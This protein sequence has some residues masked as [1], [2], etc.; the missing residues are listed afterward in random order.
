MRSVVFE[1]FGE[2]A[3]VLRIRD[4]PDPSPASGQVRVRM[5]AS[6]VNPSDLLMVRGTYTYLPQLPATPGFE[7]VGIVEQNGGGILGKYLMGKRVAV[8]NAAN[9]GWCEQAI[10]STH[11]AIPLPADL[12]QD[13]AA[14]F[15][16]NPATA[17]I[18]TRI[19]FAIPRGEWLLQTAAGS[20]LGKMVIRLGKKYGFRTL[21]IVRRPEIAEELRKLGGDE[22]IVFDPAKDD[23]GAFQERVRKIVGGTGVRYAIDP[24]GGKTAGAVAATLGHGGR[25]YLFGSLSQQP[26]ELSSRMMVTTGARIEGFWLGRWTATHGPLTKLKLVRKI[27]RLMREGII[28]TEVAERFPLDRVADAARAADQPGRRGK[29]L[30]EMA[31]LDRSAADR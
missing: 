21:N 2:P 20:V 27:S 16:V 18:L 11:Q 26:F 5:L 15:F 3:D 23:A 22:A 30:L 7:G 24:V 13:Q 4:V 17:Y 31:P 8:L 10:V 14:T 9:G 29:I 28:E 6:P 19:E 25:M 12:P 1:Q